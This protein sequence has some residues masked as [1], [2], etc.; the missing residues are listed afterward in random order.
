MSDGRGIMPRVSR[1]L[2]HLSVEEVQQKIK[3]APNFRRQQKWFIVYNA[4]VDPR[5]AVEIALH[6]G[7]TKRTV[8]QVISDYN[9]TGVAAIETPGKGGRRRGYLPL[10]EEKKFLTQFMDSAK[11]G[12]ITTIAKIKRAYEAKIEQPVDKTTIYRLLARHGWRKVMPRSHHPQANFEEQEEFKQKFPSLVDEALKTKDSNDHRPVLLMAQDEGRF[13]RLGQVMKAW[14]PSG[15]RPLV[16]KQGV[17]DYVYAYAAIAPALGRMTTLVLPFV[18]IK[19]MESFLQEV[20]QDFADYFIIMQVD[21]ASWHISDKL[22]IP[23]NIRL[24]PQTS[25]SPELNPVEHLWEA[26]RENYFDNEVFDSLE[27]VIDTLCE[28]L[29]FFNSVPEKL[30][31]MT[32]FPH[33]RITF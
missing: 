5:P 21:R 1:V 4:L 32:Y 18:N 12:L 24:I 3:T 9:R 11:K 13:G 20:S 23:E 8:H 2:P 26:I 16:A 29:N 14:C 30:K 10:A 17:R 28:G 27:K 31:S 22:T 25:R 19:M 15:H 6:T 7:T 33:L